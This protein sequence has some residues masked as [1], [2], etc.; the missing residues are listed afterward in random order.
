MVQELNITNLEEL[1]VHFDL[2]C[3]KELS[4]AGMAESAKETRYYE[5]R[6]KMAAEAAETIRNTT[7]RIT[8]CGQ[9][10]Q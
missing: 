4:K 7:L 6:A 3:A 10:G 5:G 1:A 9:L 8:F 2:I